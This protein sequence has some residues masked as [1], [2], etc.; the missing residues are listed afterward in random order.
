[1]LTGAELMQWIEQFGR[2]N[3]Q[4]FLAK[5]QD[6]RDVLTYLRVE[7]VLEMV[8]VMPFVTADT[9]SFEKRASFP[10]EGN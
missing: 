6:M 8:K 7:R 3:V 2:W 5:S 10:P 4:D 9:I 1:M